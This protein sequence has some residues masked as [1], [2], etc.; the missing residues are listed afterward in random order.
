MTTVF[1]IRHGETEWN[2][3]G[4]HQGHMDSPLTTHGESQARRLGERFRSAGISFD[5][6]YASD[7]GRAKQTVEAIC[8]PIEQTADIQWEPRL[9]ERALGVLEGLT[10]PQIK[11]KMPEDHRQHTSGDPDYRPD[12]GE[13]WRDLFQRATTTLEDLAGKHG[14][15]RIL[16]VTHGGVVSMAMRHCLGIE[17]ATPRQFHIANSALNILEWQDQLWRLRTW[18]DTAHLEGETTLDEML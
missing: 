9:R 8:T 11:E 3:Q 7:L 1:L 14:G 2:Q 6:V 15:E 12:G 4:I 5:S 13:S 16:C 17:L 10:Y 18:G